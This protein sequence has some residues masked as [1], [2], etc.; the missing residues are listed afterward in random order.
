MT[1]LTKTRKKAT[2]ERQGTEAKLKSAIG[3][4]RVAVAEVT[5]G[6]RQSLIP[7]TEL[8]CDWNRACK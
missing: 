8:E 4:T 5:D 1:V 3:I 7:G 2:P 6:K